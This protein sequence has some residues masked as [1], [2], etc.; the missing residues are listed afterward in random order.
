MNSLLDLPEL[1]TLSIGEGSLFNLPTLE[2]SGI[3]HKYSFIRPSWTNIDWDRIR[4][5]L[6][7]NFI[8]SIQ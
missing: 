6:W 8:D 7:N 5:F 3:F 1:K 2:L 4:F